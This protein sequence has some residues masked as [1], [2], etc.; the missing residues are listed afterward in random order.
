[1]KEVFREEGPLEGQ[2]GAGGHGGTW[3]L[4]EVVQGQ[5]GRHTDGLLKEQGRHEKTLQ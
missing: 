2:W 1:M 4:E 3:A 5:R